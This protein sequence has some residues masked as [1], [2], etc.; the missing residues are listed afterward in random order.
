MTAEDAVRRYYDAD[1]ER[2]WRRL[3]ASWL[4]F[5]ITRHYIDR[6]LTPSARVLD[7]GGGPGRYAI[8]LAALGHGVV[9]LDLSEASIELARERAAQAGVTLQSAAVGDARD[10][11]AY[12]VGGYDLVLV[13]GPLYH[14]L[15]PLERDSVI[16]QSLACLKPGGH[17]FY[18]FLSR[19]APIHY[20][21]K[22]APAALAESRAVIDEVLD[23][24][25]HL[26]PA[27]EGGFF[28]DAAF[29]EP[30]AL[31]A[32]LAR[33]AMEKVAL[34]GAE[35]MMAQSEAVLAGLDSAGRAAWLK[36]ALATA[37]TPAGLLGS[38]HLVFVGR[39]R[40]KVLQPG[41]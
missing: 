19:Y 2:E 5:A 24:R 9:L 4:E 32:D 35:G 30:D 18:A 1:P 33:F 37:E 28:T 39:S 26:A 16:E 10:L 6:V 31:E 20:Q 8:A 15:D 3:E 25:R 38:E 14:L 40:A 41:A 23:R 27:G 7:V 21:L 29:V 22:L 34:F 13:L 36:L 12:E 17:V 11:G